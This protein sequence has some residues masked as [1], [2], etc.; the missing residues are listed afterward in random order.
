[1]EKYNLPIVTFASKSEIAVQAKDV[2]ASIIE[3]GMELDAMVAMSA[4][5]EFF[6]NVKKAIVKGAKRKANELCGSKSTVEY[7]G[8]KVQMKETAVQYDFKAVPFIVEM[9]EDLK[10]VKNGAKTATPSSPYVFIKNGKILAQ[11]DGVPKKER[12]VEDDEDNYT[13]SIQLN[14]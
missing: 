11:I 5:E 4:Y 3:Q 1:M 9:E 8:C 14:K 10:K 13:L 6:E 2:A 12:V 7:N